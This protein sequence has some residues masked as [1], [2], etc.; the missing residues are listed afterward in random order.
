ML[1]ISVSSLRAEVSVGVHRVLHRQEPL[2]LLGQPG[3][4]L[5]DAVRNLKER[6]VAVVVG[7]WNKAI[8]ECETASV[9]LT[10]TARKMAFTSISAAA[11]FDAAASNV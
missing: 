10:P 4:T 5:D 9:K 6:P 11:F 3:G 1:I 2:N 7:V 8:A